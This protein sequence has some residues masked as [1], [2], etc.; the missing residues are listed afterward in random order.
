[1]PKIIESPITRWPGSVTLKDSV[2][3][4]DLIAFDDST[5]D[6]A[7]YLGGEVADN[8]GYLQITDVN[9]YRLAR[10][11]GLLHFV[12]SHTLAGL[13]SPLTVDNFPALPRVES[14]LLF[15]WLRDAVSAII[16][17]DDTEKKGNG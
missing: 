5:D 12:V 17:G 16:A 9:R 1:M 10:L 7:Q 8:P 6:A 3:Y 15:A 11:P 2:S 14:A 13:P 4:A